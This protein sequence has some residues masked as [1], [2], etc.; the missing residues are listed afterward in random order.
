MPDPV[1][2][3]P[4]DGFKSI[5]LK[6]RAT[7]PNAN[8]A[9][10]TEPILALYKSG[11]S[12]KD[13]G[14]KLG[15]N[16]QSVNGIIRTATKRGL[17]ESVN[18][19]PTPAVPP[20]VV[21]NIENEPVI[22]PNSFNQDPPMNTVNQQPAPPPQ[23]DFSGGRPIVGTSGGFMGAGQSV[24][25]TVERVSPPDG[26]LGTHLGTFSIEELGQN[27]GSGTYKIIKY[28]PAIKFPYEY[29]QKIAASYGDPRFPNQTSQNSSSGAARPFVARPWS[30]QNR[31]P[32]S[33]DE[34]RSVYRP[35]F[36]RPSES[37]RA[38]VEMARHTMQ[39][40]TQTG[41]MDKAIEMLG[42]MHS[43][44]L[45]QIENARKGGPET[46]I[47]GFLREQQE[48]QNERWSQERKREEERR[49]EEENK[50]QRRQEEEQRRWE[51]EQTGER[52]RHERELIRISR[53]T[54]AREKQLKFEADEREKRATEERRF[55]LEL[56][57][58]KIQLVRQEAEASQKRLEGE[59]TRARE[60][61]KEMV[62]RTTKTINE[63]QEATTRHIEESQ[64]QIQD[65][66]DREREQLEREH[67]LKEKSLDKQHELEARYLDL[68]KEQIQNSGGDQIFNTINTVIKEVSKSLEKVVDWKKLEAM[69]PEAQAAEAAK[70]NISGP[71]APEPQVQR[72]PVQVREVPV[73]GAET[74]PAAPVQQ[75]SAPRPNQ[76]VEALIKENMAR[77]EF[78]TILGEWALNIESCIEDNSINARTFAN[79]YLEMMRDPSNDAAR[80]ASAAFA[81]FMK[82]RSWK[83]MMEV[84][85]GGLDPKTQEMFEKPEAEEF[86]KQ[87]KVMVLEQIDEYWEQFLADRQRRK[88][89]G[90]GTPA[91]QAP[92]EPQGVPQAQNAAPNGQ[93][94]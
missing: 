62:D 4:V 38:L 7:K 94:P 32:G 74:Q 83:K 80:N 25:Y 44:T 86:Y 61:M 23:D 29:V 16:G 89:G 57:E 36:A 8:P 28:D 54:E 71:Q 50:W 20:A 70:V 92:V 5:P 60:E 78:Q 33:E 35:S 58:K 6:R 37:D 34:D 72:Q 69:S 88:Q 77:P 68:Q 49:R 31:G 90:N 21:Q 56:E 26:L 73:E 19:T 24:K 46:M 12:A 9:E 52:E 65:Q 39:Q 10:H 30:G 84:F 40:N 17:F 91:S 11:L 64:K 22:P 67:K 81:T 1:S 41:P 18:P 66:L 43:Q 51:R 59:L 55:L 87:F 79:Y 15:I 76:A 93:T 75:A 53:E 45:Q 13:I 14:A 2:V 48:V 85:Q 27:Y 63:N 82:P 47:T 42:N 3:Q